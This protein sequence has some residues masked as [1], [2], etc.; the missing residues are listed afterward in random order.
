MSTWLMVSKG[1]VIAFLCFLVTG[2]S[3]CAVAM[4]HESRTTDVCVARPFVA[5]EW[6]R[7]LTGPT[8][9]RLA[10]S[11]TNYSRTKVL[12]FITE[13]PRG[14]FLSG[15]T[16]RAELYDGWSFS[17]R[18]YGVSPYVLPGIYV[19]ELAPDTTHDVQVQVRR[20]QPDFSVEV[21]VFTIDAPDT[22]RL[23]CNV[24][25]NNNY[26]SIPSFLMLVETIEF[27]VPEGKNS[28]EQWFAVQSRR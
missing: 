16:D 24:A 2:V 10:I 23:L 13:K 18:T 9:S 26:Y 5:L 21:G 7:E 4:R 27:A 11:F 14:F 28:G 20:H 8:E 15:P 19:H 3:A 17:G 25:G 22:Y 6:T 12:L 1:S